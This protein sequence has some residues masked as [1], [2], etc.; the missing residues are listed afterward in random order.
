MET[1]GF[2]PYGQSQDFSVMQEVDG[3]GSL[4]TSTFD[5]FFPVDIFSGYIA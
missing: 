3:N 1:L 4:L 5:L 2:L